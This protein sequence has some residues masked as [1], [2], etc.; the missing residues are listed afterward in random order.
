LPLPLYRD[1]SS[2]AAGSLIDGEAIVCDE[3]RLAVFELIRRPAALFTQQQQRCGFLIDIHLAK[4]PVG[5]LEQR[6]LLTRQQCVF[7]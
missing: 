5:Y 1:G 2:E 3:N 7:L 4:N 6:F